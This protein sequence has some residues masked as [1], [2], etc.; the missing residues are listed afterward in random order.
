MKELEEQFGPSA[1]REVFALLR[2]ER[3]V[4]RFA[5]VEGPAGVIALHEARGNLPK[6]Q[7]L[8]AERYREP[9][10]ASAARGGV[11]KRI[12]GRPSLPP[13]AAGIPVEVA[14]AKLRQAEAEAGGARLPMDAGLLEKHRLALQKAVPPG[15]EVHALWP[16]YLAYLE[17][18][19]AEI[20][21]RQATKGPL[22]WTDYQVMRDRYARGLAFERTMVALLMED[23]ARPRA[24]RRWLRDFDQPRIE[25]HVG[26][27]KADLRFA[28][29]LVI[30]ERPPPGQAPAWRRSASRAGIS[31]EW[32]LA[33][34]KGT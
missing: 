17:R 20:G 21:Q 2:G 29:V 34:S 31:H 15:A 14:E 30:E 6:A 27:M 4:A 16:D 19:T 8:L 7:A 23:A 25:T 11:E 28:D 10:S 32:R 18:R 33:R 12:S 1:V 26:V 13:E 5:A 3:E 24:Q 22:G 9:A